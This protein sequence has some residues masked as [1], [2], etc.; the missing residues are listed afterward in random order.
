MQSK[1]R[2]F[3]R[4][5]GGLAAA[6][7]TAPMLNA[8]FIN[9]VQAAGIGLENKSAELLAQD[10][11]YWATIQ[12]AYTSSPG[13]INL[14]NGGVSPQPL[15]V[16]DALDRYNRIANEGPAYYMWSILGKGRETVRKK[17]S[18]L[19]G[20]S[21][22]EIAINRNS[23]EGL[24]TIIYGLDMKKGDEVLTSNQVYPNM[25]AAWEQRREREGIKGSS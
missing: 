17:L 20:C 16:Q 10:E 23:S 4:Q 1:R 18:L 6:S 7:V 3:I 22:E 14:N 11:D 15:I 24:E 2:H 13:V 9:K 12:Q 21:P 8:A 25:K 19:A 5:L